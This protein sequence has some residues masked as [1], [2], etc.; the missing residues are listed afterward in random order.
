ML[1]VIDAGVAVKGCLPTD[2]SLRG[3][4]AICA[5]LDEKTKHCGRVYEI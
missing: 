5:I 4:S 1:D 3:N 2:M